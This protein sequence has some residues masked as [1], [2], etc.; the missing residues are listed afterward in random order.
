MQ[1]DAPPGK[2][3]LGI[4]LTAEGPAINRVKDE[5]PLRGSICIG[6]VLTS[7]DGV[8]VKSMSA[9]AIAA[10]MVYTESKHR[11]FTVESDYRSPDDFVLE[12]ARAAT[13]AEAVESLSEAVDEVEEQET[14][15]ALAGAEEEKSEVEGKITRTL[16]A[17]PGKL[18]ILVGAGA[19]GVVVNGVK[20]GSPLEGEV[21]V[22]DVIVAFDGVDTRAMSASD[23]S[24]LMAETKD[25]EERIVTIESAASAALAPAYAPAEMVVQDD[26]DDESETAEEEEKV[27]DSEDDDTAT[28][29]SASVASRKPTLDVLYNHPDSGRLGL[30]IRAN[31]T[32]G[33]IVRKVKEG[34]PLADVVAPGDIIVSIDGVDT[35]SM[36]AAEIADFL[37]RSEEGTRMTTR[38]LSILDL[39]SDVPIIGEK[40][41]F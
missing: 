32:A 1:V 2:L 18:G 10:I 7:I 34:S 13:E 17:K 35:R 21:A 28:Q 26:D 12:Q 3:G 31:S 27:A 39:A 33:P 5:S 22:G 36:S 11:F 38:T 30:S 23:V 19:D 37:A 25:K 41:E 15:K 8:D 20:P 40:A 4:K 14:S 24:A 16:S 6:D 29:T 9:A